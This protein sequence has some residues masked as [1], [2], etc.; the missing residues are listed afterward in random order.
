MIAVKD[1]EE[2][3]DYYAQVFNQFE[4]T[5]IAL[6]DIGQLTS[7]GLDA[8]ARLYRGREIP[9]VPGQLR[10]KDGGTIEEIVVGTIMGTT[11]DDWGNYL[12]IR[13]DRWGWR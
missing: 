6:Y 10:A 13:K 9:L 7:A 4:A 11:D 8:M 5:V 3:Y 12:K 2:Q 1:E